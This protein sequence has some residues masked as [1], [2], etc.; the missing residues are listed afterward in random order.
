MGK[1]NPF[2]VLIIRHAE[3]TGK[4]DDP[5]LS[6]AGRR[7]AES[8]AAVLPRTIL[9]PDYLFAARPSK[10]S[11]RSLETVEPLARVLRLEINDKHDDSDYGDVA[12]LL[13]KKDKYVGR[14][15]LIS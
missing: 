7:R 8:L 6:I 10:K 12:R 13:L 11:R 4:D 1:K 9:R 14:T 2:Q 3:E 5:H 15:V